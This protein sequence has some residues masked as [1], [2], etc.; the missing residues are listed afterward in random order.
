[1]TQT[2]TIVASTS[3]AVITHKVLAAYALGSSMVASQMK[4]THFMALCWIFAFCSSIGIILGMVVTA[5][6]PTTNSEAVTVTSTTTTT[7]TAT[8]WMLGS[9]QAVIGGTF[10][11]VSI[12]EMGLKEILLCRDSK[13]MGHRVCQRDMA[14]SKLGAFLIGY[15]SMSIVAIFM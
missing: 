5:F 3:I 8:I 1:V 6:Y 10:L 14:W 15:I 12:V 13:L 7:T 4:E 9:I 11:Y 2:V